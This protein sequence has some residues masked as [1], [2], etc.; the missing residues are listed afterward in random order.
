MT[1]AYARLC[2]ST[3]TE[4]MIEEGRIDPRRFGDLPVHQLRLT[5]TANESPDLNALSPQRLTVRF[6]DG[7]TV[8]REIPHTLGSPGAPLSEEQAAAKCN[9]ARELAP[10][11]H[12]PRIFDQPL[13]YFVGRA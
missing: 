7:R 6:S 8:T 13:A 12:D 4:L 11:G 1:P 2:L 3:L 10:A 9:L 5:L